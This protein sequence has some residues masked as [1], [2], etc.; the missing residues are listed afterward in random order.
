MKKN[1][2]YMEMSDDELMK[3]WISVFGKGVDKDCG[4]MKVLFIKK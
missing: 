4:I 1:I 2:K 3:K